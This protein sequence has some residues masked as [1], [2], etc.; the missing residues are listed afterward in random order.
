MLNSLRYTI[1]EAFTQL[2]RNAAMSIASV[3]SITAMLLIL[4]IFFIITVN[5]SL[6]IENVKDDFDTVSIHLLD[7]TSYESASTMILQL[8]GM[9]EVDT[10]HYL[11]KDV[12]L[13]Q[14]TRDKF[15]ENADI[16]AG[17]AKNPLPNS[18]EITVT[19]LESAEKVAE[20][21]RTFDGIEKVNYYKESVDKLLKITESLRMGMLVVMV[22]LVFISIL[23]VS[24]TIKL[25]VFA[26]HKEIEIMKYVGATN[27]F[28]RGPFLTEGII[29]GMIS[30]LLSSGIV[31]FIYARV[32]KLFSMDIS[33][34]LETG[35]V[36]V[37]FMTFNLVWIF[38]ALGISIGACG[39]IVSMRRFLDT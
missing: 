34:L 6:A 33:W 37:G 25:T 8:E 23:V 26:R 36:P 2:F 7:E 39:S 5:I 22:F 15:A 18:I 30:A 21:A 19:D 17:L 27:W 29:I 35:P 11:D 16:F 13:E 1:K 38:L 14:W 12:A 3:F 32:V 20:V 31:A 24:N 28:I 4:G 10:V 9:P